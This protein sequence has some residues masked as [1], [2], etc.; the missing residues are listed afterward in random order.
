MQTR[1]AP[2]FL[3]TPDGQEADAILRRC[4]HCGFCTAT[5]PTYQLLGDELD[6]PR[7][8]I[9]LIKQ[10]LEGAAPS[11]ATQLH[12]DRCLTCRNCETTCPSGVEYGHLLDIGRK[13]VEAR[14]PR[15]AGER[16]VRWLLREGLTSPLFGPAMRVGQAVRDWLPP[17]VR[18][19]VPA[20]RDPGPWPQTPRA[21]RMLMLAGC[22]QPAMLPSIN[23]AT[24]RVLDA[25]GIQTVVA[26]GAGCCGAIRFHLNDQVGALDEMRANIDAWWPWIEPEDGSA[27]VEAIV[28][29]ASGCGVTVKD[30]GH[31]LRHDPAY[32]DK[33]RRV[34]ELTR[35]V[36]ELLPQLLPA[37]QARLGGA[38]PSGVPKRVVFHPPCTLQHGQK[39][40]GGVEQHLRAL[41]FEVQVARQEAHLCCGS[42]GTYSVLQPHVSEQLRDRKL[43]HLQADAPEVIASANIGCITHLQSGTATPVR[44]WVEVVDAALAAAG[45]V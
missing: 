10:V 6:G 29:N 24:A 45:G 2:E 9:Y 33:A 27:G 32:A 34:S 25:A 35:D 11:R 39:L 17:P 30:Y 38:L 13:V 28:M 18:A 44:H 42:A 23:A 12:L 16:A 41:G 14:V 1:L 37:W 4:V 31:A 40:R 15:P 20:R 26:P 22:V 19:K 43:A 5:C 21:R 7:G 8:R 3:S 36:S